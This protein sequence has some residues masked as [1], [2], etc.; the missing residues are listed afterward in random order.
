[1]FKESVS[2]VQE[3]VGDLALR[4]ATSLYGKM[5]DAIGAEEGPDLVSMAGG[6]RYLPAAG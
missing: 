6:L 2:G 5:K 1:M 4:E 3:R